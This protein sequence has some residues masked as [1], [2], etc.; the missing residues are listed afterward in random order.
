MMRDT[1]PV[2]DGVPVF[3]GASPRMKNRTEELKEAVL[4]TARQA[5][6][7][8]FLRAE[9]QVVTRR[10]GTGTAYEEIREAHWESEDAA[11]LAEHAQI[12]SEFQDHRGTYVLVSYPSLPAASGVLQAVP[13]LETQ[14]DSE[15][16]WIT[17]QPEIPGYLSA[18]GVALRRRR[19]PDSI[20]ASDEAAMTAL[21]EQ[22][23][24]VLRQVQEGYVRS[25]D[26]TAERAIS[27][28][29]ARAELVGFYVISRWVSPDDRY[30]YSLA[31]VRNGPRS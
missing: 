11:E 6:R 15:P 19:L 24:V 8:R 5:A 2:V 29:T 17:A 9:Y 30:M 26:G 23:V 4:H 10:A 31:V 22:Q 12:L 18:A 27:Y 7:Y 25:R 1:S 20:D 14:I 21:L 16:S 3:F 28:H 13:G